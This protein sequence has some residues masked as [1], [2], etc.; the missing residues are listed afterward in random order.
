MYEIYKKAQSPSIFQTLVADP[1]S[2]LLNLRSVL[3]NVSSSLF[4]KL[5]SSIKDG[6]RL[7]SLL[8][9]LS[10][11][12]TCLY[13]SRNLLSRVAWLSLETSL[14]LKLVGLVLLSNHRWCVADHASALLCELVSSLNLPT[15]NLLH[16]DPIFM[17]DD[18]QHSRTF[19]KKSSRYVLSFLFSSLYKLDYYCHDGNGRRLHSSLA[20]SSAFWS[21]VLLWRIEQP[22]SFKE[23]PFQQAYFGKGNQTP[24]VA[25]PLEHF[26]KS[27]YVLFTRA[28]FDH[29]LI[30]DFAK[31]AFNLESLKVSKDLPAVVNFLKLSI[32][33]NSLNLYLYFQCNALVSVC[34]NLSL[35][36][37]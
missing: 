21:C 20:L 24:L 11:V 33:E 26:F 28:N 27:S 16:P 9:T 22:Y 12:W 35:L 2:S 29:K 3:F 14:D 36:R 6:R 5:R 13:K 8:R 30:G 18:Y 1:S 4:L 25:F 32:L 17:G 19:W 15:I 34:I 37:S 10:L 31:L 7:H 23:I